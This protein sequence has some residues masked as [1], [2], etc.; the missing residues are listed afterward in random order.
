MGI[1]KWARP[2]RWSILAEAVLLVAT[3]LVVWPLAVQVE[4]G[5]E[6]VRV[7]TAYLE[8]LRD[9][10]V[11]RA[12]EYVSEDYAFDA[13]RSW[14]TPEAMSADWEIESVEL[15][16]A[17]ETTV[18][19]TLT[20]AGH[21]ADGAFNLESDDEDN[22]LITNPYVYLQTQGGI[23]STVEI[24]ERSAEIARVEGYPQAVALYPGFYPLFAS[25]AGFE[26]G[27]SLFA[28]P[29]SHGPYYYGETIDLD[30][31]MSIPL[32]ENAAVEA[33]LNEQFAAWL[34]E[35]AES[36][37]AAPEGCPFSA[38]YDY[39]ALHDGMED[40][41]EVSD[42]DWTVGAYPV[43]RLSPELRLEV[44]EPGWMGLSGKG[45]VG[46]ED[47]EEVAIDSR[48]GVDVGNVSATIGTD[49]AVALTLF[50]ETWN[51]CY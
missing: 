36:A 35:C 21:R 7:V 14:L 31:L 42:L 38:G 44:V 22:L 50:D 41:E 1:V 45:I 15:K 16:S 17:S 29:G 26:D 46:Y 10:D 3:A 48:C 12:E 28:L 34:D 51:S 20:S 40:Y 8:A 43:V 33:A 6:P 4:E 23:L 5:P 39:A 9:K 32:R 13:D 47:R 37:V 27:A 2:R 30:R 11:E 19:V 49:G 24:G 18:H 25:V